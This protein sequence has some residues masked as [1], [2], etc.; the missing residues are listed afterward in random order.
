MASILERFPNSL[1][2]PLSYAV[3]QTADKNDVITIFSAY[4]KYF[5]YFVL[6]KTLEFHHSCFCRSRD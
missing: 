6:R 1:I 4:L 5:E 2:V 3:L